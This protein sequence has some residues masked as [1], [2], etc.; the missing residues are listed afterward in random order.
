MT[1]DAKLKKNRLQR[2]NPRAH[3][4][5]LVMIPL[6]SSEYGYHIGEK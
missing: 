5:Y 1:G 3:I 4:G 2:L 6:I